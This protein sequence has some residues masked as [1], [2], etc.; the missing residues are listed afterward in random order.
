MTIVKSKFIN[1][2]G[3]DYGAIIINKIN[4]VEVIDNKIINNTGIN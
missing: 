4:I 3:L 1:N 2:W